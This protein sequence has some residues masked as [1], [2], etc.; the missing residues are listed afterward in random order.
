MNQLIK[1][2]GT[3][4]VYIV[5]IVSII[6][7]DCN[8]DGFQYSDDNGYRLFQTPSQRQYIK[9]EVRGCFMNGGSMVKIMYRKK[10][11]IY[12]DFGRIINKKLEE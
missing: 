10:E 7:F 5:Y 3:D 8:I 2:I 11:E 9:W 1:E 12:K 6:E 4:T